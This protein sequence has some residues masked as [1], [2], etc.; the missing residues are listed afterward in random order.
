M[1]TS[2]RKKL[3]YYIYIIEESSVLVWITSI[4]DSFFVEREVRKIWM[5]KRKL[6]AF[7]KEFQH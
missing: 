6:Q 7:I 5:K 3:K 4:F 1:V 2:K